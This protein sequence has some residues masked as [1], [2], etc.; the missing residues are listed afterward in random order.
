MILWFV[1]PALGDRLCTPDA[2]PVQLLK[3]FRLVREDVEGFLP[4]SLINGF[5]DFGPDPL[6][7]VGCPR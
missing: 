7:G 2:A 1:R 5:C 3:S 6:D 4:K